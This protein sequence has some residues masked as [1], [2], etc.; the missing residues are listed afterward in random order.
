MAILTAAKHHIPAGRW[1]EYVPAKD[2]EVVRLEAEYEAA[3]ASDPR[4]PALPH[5]QQ[6]IRGA[7]V[8]ASRSKW[9]TFVES[10]DRRTNPRQFWQLL[11]KL[12]GKKVST[13]PNQPIRFGQRFYSKPKAIARR[14]NV[15][16]TNIR[17]H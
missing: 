12:S 16:Y 14:F 11:K 5:L 3:R 8:S 6:E 15:Q 4:D 13:P 7:Q 17:V 9:R 2:A 1:R 10:N